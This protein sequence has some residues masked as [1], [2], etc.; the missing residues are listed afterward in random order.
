M[1]VDR[2]V[3]CLEMLQNSTAVQNISETIL[4][5]PLKSLHP[6]RIFLLRVWPTV[7]FGRRLPVCWLILFLVR[8]S[9]SFDWQLM[10]SLLGFFLESLDFSTLVRNTPSSIPRS[11]LDWS[12]LSQRQFFLLRKNSRIYRFYRIY[13]PMKTNF[14]ILP[15]M[16]FVYSECS[17]VGCWLYMPVHLPRIIKYCS[18]RFC[19]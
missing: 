1:P 12:Q 13:N 6:W 8:N 10:T 14:S 4:G 17:S 16:V 15:W 7:C 2:R 3:Q 5:N 18:E 11:L 9:L 19:N